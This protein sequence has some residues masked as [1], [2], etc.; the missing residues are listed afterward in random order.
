[1]NMN[2]LKSILDSGACDHALPNQLD[3]L[4]EGRYVT[5]ILIAAP[6]NAM[7]R[8]SYAVIILWMFLTSSGDLIYVFHSFSNSING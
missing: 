8:F 6:Q 1:M 5:L 7:S 2:L 3:M 4:H